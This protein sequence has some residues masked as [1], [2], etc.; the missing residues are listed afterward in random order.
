MRRHIL[1]T[2]HAA[3]A[4]HM[5]RDRA[6]QC[7]AI[8]GVA[9]LPGQC[10]IG[11]RQVRLVQNIAC[12]RNFPPGKKISALV[13]CGPSTVFAAPFSQPL[14]FGVTGTPSS[15]KEMAGAKISSGA[16][17]PKRPSASNQPSTAPGTL[18]ES[19]PTSG[20]CCIPRAAKYSGVI[21]AGARPLPFSAC[22]CP[23]FASQI[24]IN[25]SP[26]A[27]QVEG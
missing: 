18:I 6:C 23:V 19:G 25:R 15:A 4:L 12:T 22:S 1:H 10:L 20:I 11:A 26:P 2:E 13:S 8:E 5:L 9:S 17:L 3:D 27:E 21:P 14:S 7:A 16:R 24:N